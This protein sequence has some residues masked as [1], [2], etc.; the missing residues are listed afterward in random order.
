VALRPA[1][2]KTFAALASPAH[3]SRRSASLA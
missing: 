1:L 3:R 2:A